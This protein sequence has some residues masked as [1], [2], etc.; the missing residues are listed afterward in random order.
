MAASS[1]QNLPFLILTCRWCRTCRSAG[2]CGFPCASA[3]PGSGLHSGRPRR[4]DACSPERRWRGSC[5]LTG[6]RLRQGSLRWW[7]KQG[8]HYITNLLLELC[9][10]VRLAK[11]DSVAAAFKHLAKLGLQVTFCQW[12]QTPLHCIAAT[13]SFL[14]VQIYIKTNLK[15]FPKVLPTLVSCSYLRSRGDSVQRQGRSGWPERCLSP[16]GPLRRWDDHVWS[17]APPRATGHRSEQSLSWRGDGCKSVWNRGRMSPK[18]GQ[19][20]S[21]VHWD[22]VFSRILGFWRRRKTKTKKKTTWK[23]KNKPNTV[24]R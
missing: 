1:P 15:L 7:R 10:Q 16:L 9:K 17:E 19:R 23:D 4:W 5:T 18:R 13:F 11:T 24:G 22:K 21:L 12:H 2:R 8:Q 20:I 3:A 14:I 6:C